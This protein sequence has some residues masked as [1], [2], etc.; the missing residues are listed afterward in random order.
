MM[1]AS[2]WNRRIRKRKRTVAV[3]EGWDTSSAQPAV[4]EVDG[5]WAG[6]LKVVCPPKIEAIY[7]S[8]REH[9]RS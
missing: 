3:G 4:A 5:E 6:A 2:A 7:L 8:V 1:L 9:T